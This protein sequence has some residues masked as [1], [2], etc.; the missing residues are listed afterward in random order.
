MKKYIISLLLVL[1]V[2]VPVLS[3]A[4]ED[5]DPNPDS[6]ACV[7][8]THDLR[9]RSRDI[10]TGGDVSALQ[11]FLQSQN[12]LN[13]EPTG[14]F[15][16][17]TLKAVKDFQS[18]NSINPTG[19]V[20][21]VTRAKIK[22]LTCGDVAVT[23]APLPT[24]SP[25]P[26]NDNGCTPGALYNSRTGQPCRTNQ[27]PS[28]C[29]SLDGFSTMTGEPCRT[30]SIDTL[31]ILA[32]KNNS[33]FTNTID[34]L[35]W[36]NPI[37]STTFKDN[38]RIDL[39]TGDHTIVSKVIS[40]DEAD[41]AL[42]GECSYFL[43][44]LYSEIFTPG[45]YQVVVS[46][47]RTSAMDSIVYIVKSA[48]DTSLT[49][50]SPNGGEAWALGSTQTIKW[51]DTTS[52]VSSHAISLFS[53]GCNTSPCPPSS[54]YSIGNVGGSS[55]SWTVG[56]SLYGSVPPGSYTLQV[57]QNGTSICDTSDSYFKIT[58]TNSVSEI[59]SFSAIT[60]DAD[61]SY[62][63]TVKRFDWTTKNT[64]VV[65]LITSGACPTG[66]TITVAAS[67]TPEVPFYCGDVDRA[68]LNPNDSIYLRFI[69]TSGRT[70]SV[71]FILEPDRNGLLAKTFSVSI[72]P[73][74]TTAPQSIKVLSP[75]GGEVY[76]VGDTLTV[77][78]TQGLP[79]IRQ[80]YLDRADGYSN[81][82]Y[83]ASTPNTS[84]YWSLSLPPNFPAGDYKAKLYYSDG[85]KDFADASDDT[86]SIVVPPTIGTL[87]IPTTSPLANA[88][89]GQ[90]YLAKIEILGNVSGGASWGLSG[91]VP[92]GL[93]YANPPTGST[94]SNLCYYI[95]GVPD[96]SGTYTF[97]FQVSANGQTASK[98]FSITVEPTA[99]STT[100]PFTSFG[101]G[102]CYNGGWY[103]PGYPGI[104][105]IPSASNVLG[106][107]TYHFTQE[108]MLGA[109]GTEVKE[110]QKYLQSHGYSAGPI[111]GIFGAS[112]HKAVVDFQTSMNLWADGIVGPSTRAI[113]NQ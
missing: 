45:T 38:Y 46:N 83:A 6:S 91:N 68:L 69:N 19:F 47:T 63:G 65:N 33:I 84:G 22:A 99:C 104:S 111:D 27:F 24:P 72:P 30:T 113:L 17:L 13:S 110:L 50:L 37:S 26:S 77:K 3:Y 55:Y 74:S 15:G 48:P 7:S 5:V 59:T 62:G 11:D 95:G 82:I 86:F 87:S 53:Y 61:P 54:V 34:K 52:G 60:V 1:S 9:Y 14:Y 79:G 31:T 64:S 10:T 106:A 41:C 88:Q 44:S 107:S 66:V 18:A 43:L 89:M 25:T 92:S 109:T 103:P 51:K 32:P 16:L 98:Q 101:G 70:A 36:T 39:K 67:Q 28:G 108:L 97:T 80:I 58:S 20:G 76:K 85:G 49:I 57:C 112:L 35:R 75:N 96:K 40:R 78:W 8:I 42:G 2:L 71:K 81:N 21:P 4:Q 56:Q 90:N 94:C 105:M 102:T 12:Y 93:G 100:D 23:P 29:S 73:S